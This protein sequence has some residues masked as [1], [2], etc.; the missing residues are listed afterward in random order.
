MP[1]AM[2]CK[3]LISQQNL[4]S[5]LVA[6][7]SLVVQVGL[8]CSNPQENTALNIETAFLS[9]LCLVVCSEVPACREM[10]DNLK[11]LM[12]ELAQLRQ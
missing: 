10:T 6:V 3:V 8:S 12:E 4:H 5:L 2:L 9:K 11:E 1:N 7:L